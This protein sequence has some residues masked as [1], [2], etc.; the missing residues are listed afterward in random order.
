MAN[1]C[2]LI[3]S[4]FVCRIDS[5]GIVTGNST[6]FRHNVLLIMFNSM[7]SASFNFFYC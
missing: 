2:S 5:N 4:K 6:V 1:N 7:D 3:G